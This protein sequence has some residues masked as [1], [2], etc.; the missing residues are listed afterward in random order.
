MGAGKSLHRDIWGFVLRS[1]HVSYRLNF[2]EVLL[3]ASA[4]IVALA[5]VGA[6]DLARRWIA[7]D[8]TKPDP[9]AVEKFEIQELAKCQARISVIDAT[10]A[11]A[12]ASAKAELED[13]RS[14]RRSAAGQRAAVARWK[15]EAEQETEKTEDNGGETKF[16]DLD[17]D[18]QMAVL[19]GMATVDE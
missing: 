14:E 15:K 9:Q 6:W 18:T 5:A 13:A 16:E 3:V 17:V 7:H 19:E 1:P 12:I 10:L 2:V 8:A 4:G 11:S